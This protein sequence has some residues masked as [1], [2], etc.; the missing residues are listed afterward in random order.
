MNQ[1]VCVIRWL[2]SCRP[3]TQESELHFPSRQSGGSHCLR[4]LGDKV[5][6]L[7]TPFNLVSINIKY[8]ALYGF[9]G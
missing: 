4:V 6:S 9:V 3:V 5:D 7:V 2:F 1:F 8:N